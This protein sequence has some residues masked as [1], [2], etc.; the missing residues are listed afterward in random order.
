MSPEQN[1]S[2]PFADELKRYGPLP[3]GTA[4]VLGDVAIERFRQVQKGY[5]AEHDDGYTPADQLAIEAASA[6]VSD[7]VRFLGRDVLGIVDC[8]Q[9]R[10]DELIQGIAVAVAEVERLDRWTA[11][12]IGTDD[13][14]R[15]HSEVSAVDDEPAD[16]ESPGGTVVVSGAAP[17]R[18]PDTADFDNMHHAL[19]RPADP[20][21]QT[22]RNRFCIGLETSQAARFR[23][24]ADYWALDGKINEDRDGL[25][26]VTQHGRDA[27]ALFM[28]TGG[29]AAKPL[30]AQV[31]KR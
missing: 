18:K 26:S 2:H 24:L 1:V 23:E 27:L 4:V 15:T 3:A 12:N 13:D 30:L 6:I 31:V 22:Y 7:G 29:D 5:T 9:P 14:D 16:V 11:A 21:V 25:F 20:L 8:G 17:V 19:G 28:T 10:R